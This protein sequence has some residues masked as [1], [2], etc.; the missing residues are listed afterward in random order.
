MTDRQR[1][2]RPPSDLEEWALLAIQGAAEANA[3][4]EA[5]ERRVS[6]LEAAAG[7]GSTPPGSVDVK[8]PSGWRA[9]GSPG[10][11][12]VLA[13]FALIAFLKNEIRAALTFLFG[14]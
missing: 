3:R 2:Q 4:A 8:S 6:S 10:V 13:L 12:V 9:K 7:S 5:L 1:E 11:V 14:R